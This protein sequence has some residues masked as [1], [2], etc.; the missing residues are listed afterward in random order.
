[1]GSKPLNVRVD[2]TFDAREWLRANGYQDIASFIDGVIRE[3][4][5]KG[6]RTR[7]NWWLVLAG[8]PATGKPRTVSGYV[9]PVLKA[10]RRRQGFP[11]D[12]EGAIERGPHELAPPIKQQARWGKRF[13]RAVR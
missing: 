12:V 2:T 8:T 7:R 5:A 13:R 3:W 10:A 4:E 9:F 11:P 1:M 6:L